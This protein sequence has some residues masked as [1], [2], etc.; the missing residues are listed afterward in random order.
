MANNIAAEK[1]AGASLH[2]VRAMRMAVI[3]LS[4]EK[5]ERQNA[6]QPE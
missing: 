6:S 4:H 2:P 1:T 3:R 5:T